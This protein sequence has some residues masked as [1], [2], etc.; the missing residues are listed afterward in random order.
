MTDKPTHASV[1][2]PGSRGYHD[3]IFS[4]LN[5]GRDKALG[6]VSDEALLKFENFVHSL[7]FCRDRIKRASASPP[8]EYHDTRPHTVM[9]RCLHCGEVNYI[10]PRTLGV[11]CCPVHDVTLR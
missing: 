1:E 8:A 3:E 2:A 5:S 11:T 6:H 9:F 10:N 4:S 7:R